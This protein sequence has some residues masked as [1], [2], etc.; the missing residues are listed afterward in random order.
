MRRSLIVTVAA[1][2]SMVLLAMLVPMAVLVRSYALEDRLSRAALEV[3]A[4]ESVVSGQ[5]PGAIS[6]YV[7]KINQ[8]GDGTTTDVI[9][10]PSTEHPDGLVIGP[11]TDLDVVRDS[12]VLQARATGQARVDDVSGGVQILV[13]VSLGGSSPAAEQTTVIRIQVDPPG[14]DSDI[15]RSLVVLLALGIAL[16]AGALVLADRLGRS[17]VS[18][19][20]TL[21]SHAQQLG[22]RGRPAKV[23]ASGPPE[24]RDLAHAMNRLV[25]RIEVL[26]AREREGVSD[27]SHRL[28]TPMTALRLRVDALSEPGDRD[29]LGADLDELESMVDHVV[30]EARRSEREG[31]VPEC[32][33]VAVITERVEF[34][35]PLAE[36]QGRDYQLDVQVAGPVLVR[37][38]EQDLQAL[39]DVL[40]DNLFTHTPEGVA[41]R[42]TVTDRQGGGLVLTMDDGGPGLPDDFDVALRG[43]SGAGST[44][45]GLSIV[46]KTATESGGGLVVGVSPEGG[47]QVVVE[48]GPRS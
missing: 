41:V 30:T 9:Y 47:A 11:E 35:R 45:L 28:R 2:V 7:T 6:V 15:V 16:L 21:A 26:L 18:P 8:A 5:D 3:Q 48:L 27:L 4:T 17:F 13:P 31:L 23:A 42:I 39:T 34:W 25:D 24:V 33:G 40:L 37:A 14:L 38:S 29:R 20:R 43:A 22:E 1:A 44:G 12:R 46:N 36:D 10:P 19:I 32:E